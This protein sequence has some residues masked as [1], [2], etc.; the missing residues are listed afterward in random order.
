M[1]APPSPRLPHRRKPDARPR[2]TAA[3]PTCAAPSASRHRAPTRPCRRGRWPAPVRG[4]RMPGARPAE[5]IDARLRENALWLLRS[6]R[7]RVTAAREAGH[8]THGDGTALD[9]VP[10][11]AVD[12][13]AWDASAGTLARD[14]GWTAACGASGARPACPLVPAIQFVGYDGYPGHGSPRTCRPPTCA[15]HLHVSWASPC[16]GTS[17]PSAPCAW[18]STFGAPTAAR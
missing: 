6:Y 2:S 11:E 10:A 18:V 17:A 16:Y 7:L 12:Q 1:G 5:A 9:L 14:L 3:R 4:W 13:A 8:N 15:A